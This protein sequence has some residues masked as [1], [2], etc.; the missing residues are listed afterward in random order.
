VI[1]RGVLI[2]AAVFA[3]GA[4]AQSPSGALRLGPDEYRFSEKAGAGSSGTAGIQ[5]TVLKGD[6]E[7]PGLYTIMLK[8]PPNT[9]IAAHAH[10]DDRV[11]TVV[12]GDWSIG[13][14]AAFDT[15][16]LKRLAPGGYY[17]EPPGLA[18]YARTGPAGAVV[19][20]TGYGPTDTRPVVPPGRGEG[21]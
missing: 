11:A 5:S 6:P 18:H 21:G 7:K 14:G 2:V 1:R 15:A 17:T 3:A 8:I 10:R 13:Y 9:S 16:G 19:M 12:S 4:A 20:I